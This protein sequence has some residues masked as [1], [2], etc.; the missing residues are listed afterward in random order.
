MDTLAFG[1]GTICKDCRAISSPHKLAELSWCIFSAVKRE[2]TSPSKR[3]T[4]VDLAQLIHA[5]QSF[6]T[7]I[8]Y[9]TGSMTDLDGGAPVVVASAVVTC[10][11]RSHRGFLIEPLAGVGIHVR[12]SRTRWPGLGGVSCRTCLGACRKRCPAPRNSQCIRACDGLYR[13]SRKRQNNTGEGGDHLCES[14]K[15]GF[16]RG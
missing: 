12:S 14:T 16:L 15:K 3:Q 1:S 13:K 8:Y 6:F 2:Q 7:V 10:C 4:S 5:A 11:E 9:Y